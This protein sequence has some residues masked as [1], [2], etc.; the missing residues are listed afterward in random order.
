MEGFDAKLVKRAL[1]L[2]NEAEINMIVAVGKGTDEGIYG[3]RNR[4][5][6]E[7]VVFKR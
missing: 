6:F 5:P 4:L 1:R 7:E 2:P 3:K